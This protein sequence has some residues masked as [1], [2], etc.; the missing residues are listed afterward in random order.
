[1]RLCAGRI[2]SLANR[3]ALAE[4]AVR[5]SIG[6]KRVG[7]PGNSKCTAQFRPDQ[8]CFAHQA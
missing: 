7:M 2:H 1:M 6:T 3:Y 8:P 4:A 5:P